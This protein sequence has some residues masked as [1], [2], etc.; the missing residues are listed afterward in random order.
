MRILSTFTLV[1]SLTACVGSTPVVLKGDESFVTVSQPLH[2]R[3]SASSEVAGEYCRQYGKRAVFLSDACPEPKCAERS[4][5][6]W[7][8]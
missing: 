3:K 8:R 7:C 1:A 6:Y 4:I 2:T 5:T